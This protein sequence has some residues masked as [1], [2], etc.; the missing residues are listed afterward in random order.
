MGRECVAL[1]RDLVDVMVAVDLTP[2]SIDGA[3]CL[4]CD[5][6]DRAAVGALVDE[7]RGLGPM[8]ALVHAAGISPSMADARR[9]FEVDLVGTWNV[10]EGFEALVQPGSAAV[11]FSSSAAY[12]LAPF[13]D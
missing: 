6:S 10:L 8:R 7:A 12:Q 11:C 2:P 1:L 13:V 4:A 3:V 5:V 9:V